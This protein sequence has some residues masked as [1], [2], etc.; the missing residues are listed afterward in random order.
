ME[1]LKGYYDPLVKIHTGDIND[2]SGWIV[3]MTAIILIIVE[4]RG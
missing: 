1:A 4:V 3:I 2:Y